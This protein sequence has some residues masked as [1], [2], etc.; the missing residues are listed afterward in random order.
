[1]SI[2]TETDR[3]L[4][5]RACRGERAAFGVLFDRHARAV[6]NYLFRRTASWPDAEDL[7]SAVFLHAW[8]ARA[9]VVLHQDSALPWL[10]GVARNL[11]ANSG[12][13]LQRYQLLRA[14]LPPPAPSPDHADDVAARLDDER[15]MATLLR[16][17]AQLSDHDREVLELCVWSGLDTHG[18]AA[19]LG[20]AAGTVKSRLHRA[21]ARLRK[22][23]PPD[24]SDERARADAVT[25]RRSAFSQEAS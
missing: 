4:W 3:E 22:L 16:A 21:R 2:P 24:P 25:G 13:A 8:R 20:V 19:V 18:A 15:T 17:M 9:D 12:R 10:L 6:H 5:D 23:V 7:T 14:R 11:A 1:M